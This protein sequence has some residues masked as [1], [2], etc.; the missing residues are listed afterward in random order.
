MSLDQQVVHLKH[1]E[2]SEGGTRYIAV[3]SGKGGVGKTLLSVNLGKC[4]SDTGKKVLIVD[5]DLGLSN[6]HLMLG[7]TPRRNLTHFFFGEATFEDILV[8]VSENLHFISSGSGILELAKLP[9]DQV[10]SLIRRL[11]ELAEGGYEVVIFDT[12]PGIHEDTIAV[13]SAVD[14]PIILTTPEPTAVADAYA[15]IKVVNREA[16]TESFSLVVNKVEG[17]VEGRKVYESIRLLT[18]RFTRAKVEFLGSIR[19]RKN[20]I[21]RI[22]DQDPYDRVFTSD[23]YNILSKMDLGVSPKRRSFW[24]T[25][26]GRLFGR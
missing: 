14:R 15:L 2:G 11:Q 1:R 3:A 13:V 24:D 23:V 21:R 16:G 4:I 26:I 7:I 6:V 25:L 9:K 18:D 12:P 5:A 19:Y 20:L 10:L 22:I 17:E 8:R